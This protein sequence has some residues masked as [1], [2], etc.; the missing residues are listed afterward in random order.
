MRIFNKLIEN[1]LNKLSVAFGMSLTELEFLTDCVKEVVNAR[2]MIKYSFALLYF[3]DQS[4]N[5][6][7]IFT[8]NQM[9]L[10]DKID[11]VSDVLIEANLD[12]NLSN[13][14]TDLKIIK[15]KPYL[16]RNTSMLKKLQVTVNKCAFDLV[17]NKIEIYK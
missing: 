2:N 16:I 7:H 11:E 14:K 4:H 8:H 10:L 15:M 13:S 9:L 1:K 12:S 5:L 3:M 17:K 6:F